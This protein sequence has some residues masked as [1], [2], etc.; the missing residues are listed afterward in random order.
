LSGDLPGI[1]LEMDET[2]YHIVKE[3]DYLTGS[4][5]Y[6]PADFC[7][8]GFVHC[9][10]ENSVIKV[11]NEYY[12]DFGG[13]LLLLKINPLKLRSETR[14]E[15][16]VPV[17]DVE[18]GNIDAS[19]LFPHVYGPIDNCAVEGVAVLRKGKNGHIWPTEFKS[20]SGYIA[21]AE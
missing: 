21:T 3:R 7:E 19:S 5:G 18:T 12:S 11:A 17:N 15:T 4:G 1:R 2:I 9:A 14:Y 13:T 20:L 10:Y 6:T 16:A 8:I